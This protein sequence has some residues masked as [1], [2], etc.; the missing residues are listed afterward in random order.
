MALEAGV[1]VM[2]PNPTASPTTGPGT[3]ARTRALPT[4]ALALGVRGLRSHVEEGGGLRGAGNLEHGEA[5]LVA[6]DALLLVNWW[7]DVFVGCGRGCATSCVH[8]C[9]VQFTQTHTLTYTLSHLLAQIVVAAAAAGVAV[10]YDGR[11][12]AGIAPVFLV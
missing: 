5:R 6:L 10:P 3:G 12:A 1:V 9:T 7:C 11:H 2:R 8:T 4:L